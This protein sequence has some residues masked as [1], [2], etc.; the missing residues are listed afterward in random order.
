MKQ[1]TIEN[2]KG[3]DMLIVNDDYASLLSQTS[4]RIEYKRFER[5]VPKDK[6]STDLQIKK[7]D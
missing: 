2:E 7:N 3:F 4:Q 6:K 1:Y 5:F